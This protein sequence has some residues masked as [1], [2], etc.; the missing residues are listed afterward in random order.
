MLQ[1]AEYILHEASVVCIALTLPN[2]AGP[3]PTLAPEI[4]FP[5]KRQVG[6]GP[7]GITNTVFVRAVQTLGTET[8]AIASLTCLE[9]VI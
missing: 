4:T 1:Q 7:A 3:N 6:I 8:H 9:Y 5:Q 2:S